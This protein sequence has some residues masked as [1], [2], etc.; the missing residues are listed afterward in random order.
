MSDEKLSPEEAPKTQDADLEHQSAAENIAPDAHN[1]DAPE[2][3]DAWELWAQIALF[4]AS[5]AA[6][7]WF[8]VWLRLGQLSVYI[9]A[10]MLSTLGF[11][12][13]PIMFWGLMK[14]MLNRPVMR[15]SRTIAFFALIGVAFFCNIPR[16][17]VPLST[18]SWESTHTYRLPFKG[19]WTAL[20]GGDT[21]QTNYH[22]TTATY[23]WGY[24]F[25]PLWEGKI[26]KNKGEALE[27][28]AC[29]GQPVFAP[30]SGE[31]FEV[32]RDMEDNTP[33]EFPDEGVL[34]NHLVLRVD[35]AE[36]LYIAHLKE[37]SI[38]FKAGDKVSAGDKVGACGNSGRSPWPHL[39]VHLQN[40]ADFPVAESLPLRFS[41]Y[42]AD[43]EPVE[44]GMPK[45]TK[46]PMDWSAQ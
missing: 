15:R 16:F 39:H 14:A 3:V 40:S 19:E 2:D 1:A 8:L 38:P 32:E 6:I 31:V 12:T 23:R 5:L 13:L 44:L 26:Y 41:N 10:F 24:D 28:Y 27:D 34:G 18:E 30:V 11:L 22:A 36:F 37:K 21:V 33:G 20:A 4:M 29:F 43:G 7:G 46:N 45:G 9:H 17:T 35:D 25:S 42:R